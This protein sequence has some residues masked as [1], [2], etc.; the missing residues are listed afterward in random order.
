MNLSDFQGHW[1]IITGASAGIGREFSEH[2]ARYK[3]NLV[4]VARRHDLLGIVADGLRQSY[5]IQVETLE[6]DLAESDSADAL[7]H[8]LSE[9]SIRPKLLV[10]NAGV[11]RWGRFEE[12]DAT[13]YRRLVSLNAQATMQ[14]CFAMFALL[15]SEAPSAIINVSSP[16]AFQPMPFMAAY[17][18]SK[19][20]VH[21]LSLALYE[22]WRGHG[23]YVQTLVP[24]P[25]ATEFDTLAGAYPSQLTAQRDPSSKAVIASLE[26]F[27]SEEPLVISASGSVMQQL[28]AALAPTRMVLDKVAHMFRPPT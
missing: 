11:G 12:G 26:G 20:F 25:T 8:F 3:L 14:T 16:A 23:I 24:G 21:H 10:N 15:A 1:A 17:G 19:A 4:L 22:E 28:F 13:A 6:L 27:D 7:G 2:L 18:A 5:G 9:H